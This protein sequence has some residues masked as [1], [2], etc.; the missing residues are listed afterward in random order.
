MKNLSISA[1]DNKNSRQ[2][3]ST[4]EAKQKNR[5]FFAKIKIWI[6]YLAIISLERIFSAAS[7]FQEVFLKRVD[8]RYATSL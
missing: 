3:V 4:G 1:V 5:I 8:I 2:K 7:T 6:V